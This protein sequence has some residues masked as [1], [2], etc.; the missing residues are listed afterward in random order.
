MIQLFFQT[1]WRHLLKN[2]FYTSV[3]LVGLML[4]FAVF[5]LILLYYNHETTYEQWN[6]NSDRLFRLEL[7][8]K[9]ADGKIE[10]SITSTSD[11]VLKMQEDI[12]EI[13]NVVRFCVFE[14]GERLLNTVDK[15]STYIDHILSSD[16]V[17]FNVFRHRFIYGDASTALNRPES[18]VLTKETAERLFGNKNPVGQKVFV[19]GRFEYVVSGVIDTEGI[20]SHFKFDALRNMRRKHD[21]WTNFNYYSYVL[22]KKGADKNEI[23]RKARKTLLNIEAFKKVMGSPAEL[24]DFGITFYPVQKI[25]LYSHYDNEL[26]VNG[27][28]V[29]VNIML[30]LSV[31][32]L[33]ISFVNFTNLSVVQTVKRAKEIALKK[34]NGATKACIAR[35][36]FFEQLALVSLSAFL[37]I[38]FI[39]LLL[40]WFNNLFELQLSLT[41]HLPA[42]GFILAVLMLVIFVFAVISGVYPVSLILHHPPALVLK[43]SFSDSNKGTWLRKSLLV[44]QFAISSVFIISLW[45]V[46]LQVHHLKNKDVGFDSKQV[47]IVKIHNHEMMSDFRTLKDRIRSLD[48]VKGVSLCNYEP[49]ISGTQVQGRTHK[50]NQITLAMINVDFDYF[51]VLGMRLKEGRFFDE[52]FNSDS[53]AIILNETAVKEYG[54]KRPLNEVLFD[55]YPVVGIIKDF[56][57]KKADVPV[58]PTGFVVNSGGGEKDKML[59]KYE[60]NS[61]DKL[62]GDIGEV[63]KEF[64]P[65]FP[66]RY[67]FLDDEYAKLYKDHERL[68]QLFLLFTL[69]IT[70]ITVV[71]LFAIVAYM[72]Q[73]RTR[74]MA[75]RKV[76]GA[77]A[78]QLIRL[79]QN[80]FIKLT[81]L[82][83]CIAV[84]LAYLFARYWLD[85]FAYRIH[86]PWLPFILTVLCSVVI[87]AFITRVQSVLISRSKPMDALNS[88]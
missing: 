79:L 66:I 1:A 26:D 21:E 81:M 28:A 78:G 7:S 64:E 86:I 63:L 27:N 61:P 34:V 84:P 68:E 47:L 55:E 53:S 80:D 5:G 20:T 87:T 48:N 43:G 59:I 67:T 40:P 49:G 74:E 88:I 54:L 32:I 33:I 56:N 36:F 41:G 52:K 19:S 24:A 62:I 39:E 3:K 29:M 69:V 35:Q 83:N 25:H 18:M 45:I 15:K 72:I 42:F 71:G 10:R 14:M 44:A 31:L 82:G 22:L 11:M 38:L 2:K 46:A 37:G 73:L 8:Y 77:S 17:F 51:R 50:G 6:E 9:G 65:D 23:E 58:A 70:V 12:P 76:L 60:G 75:I 16:S 57:Q 4:G 30:T 85:G 13:E